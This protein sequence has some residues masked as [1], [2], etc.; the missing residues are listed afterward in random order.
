[1]QTVA[2]DKFQSLVLSTLVRGNTTAIP[3]PLP[4]VVV[5][6]NNTYGTG[7]AAGFS[8]AYRKA[9]GRIVFN[10]TVLPDNAKST[11]QDLATKKARRIVIATNNVTW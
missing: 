3:K 5:Y 2:P 9:G 6:E 11:V 7:L 4:V 8:D 10:T 1:M